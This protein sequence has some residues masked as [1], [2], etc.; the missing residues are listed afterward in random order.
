MARSLF[1]V[2]MWFATLSVA[3]VAADKPVVV[4]VAGLTADAPAGWKAEKPANLLRSFQFKLPTPDTGHADAELYV[5]PNAS[6]DAAKNFDKWKAQF[7][8]PDGKT[9][10]DVTTVTKFE[11]GGATVHVLDVAGTWKYR[12]RPNDPKSKEELRPEF[13]AVW[14]VVVAK[15]E[16]AHVRLSG[17]QSVV[18]KHRADFQKWLK[19]LK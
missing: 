17:H 2:A 7:T 13:R 19:S 8:P 10:A 12:E 11:A 3:A 5:S 15:D 1:A 6:P 14:V 18:E 16:A 4:T 9:A